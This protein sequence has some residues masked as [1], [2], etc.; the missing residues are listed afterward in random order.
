MSQAQKDFAF[1]CIKFGEKEYGMGHTLA[2]IAWMESSLG[3]D[4]YHGK[5]NSKTP[6]GITKVT[7]NT[8]RKQFGFRVWIHGGKNRSYGKRIDRTQMRITCL[9][10]KDNIRYIKQW[11]RNRGITFT[12]REA[13][14]YAAQV[15]RDG[16]NWQK[17]VSYG[18]VFRQRVKFLRAI[19][20]QRELE[21]RLTKE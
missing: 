14:Q 5:K 18:E 3:A 10:Y 7:G 16:T 17:R 19:A 9:I 21:K 1:E 6:F 11:G 13:W 8:I 12:N 15:Y 2:A 4:I 20:R